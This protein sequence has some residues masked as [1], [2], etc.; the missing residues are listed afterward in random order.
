MST[1]DGKHQ[2][3]DAHSFHETK[4]SFF[5]RHHHSS[6][7]QVFLSILSCATIEKLVKQ[8]EQ[9][10]ELKRPVTSLPISILQYQ[11]Q[12]SI[13]SFAFGTCLNKPKKEEREAQK[14]I[15]TA[16]L[17]WN[18]QQPA[19]PEDNRTL[20]VNHGIDT[21]NQSIEQKSTKTRKF[22]FRY[23]FGSGPLLQ[24]EG[25]FRKLWE[26]HFL[27]DRSPSNNVWVITET[28]RNPSLHQLLVRKT[29]S[30]AM[31]TKMT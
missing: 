10:S 3:S 29:P 5:S 31:L 2:N 24:F 27:S 15:D 17:Q 13:L 11:Y 25:E 8:R 18:L 6:R 12:Y 14:N 19:T 22:I 28:P 16:A 20:C 9:C 23:S 30:R 21:G 7:V 26:K 1:R 4:N